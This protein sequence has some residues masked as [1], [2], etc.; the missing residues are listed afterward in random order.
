MHDLR[1]NADRVYLPVS[2]AEALDLCWRN[3]DGRH[4]IRKPVVDHL[5]NLRVLAN[6]NEDW[7]ARIAA[8]FLPLFASSF[9]SR[10]QDR[11]GMM[12]VLRE[13]LPALDCLS[14]RHVRQASTAA[15]SIA[16]Y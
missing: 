8:D 16:R 15:E 10:T 7:R 11:D 13:S 3:A 5:R 12:G 6:E 1:V 2:I 14:C 4:V 9:P